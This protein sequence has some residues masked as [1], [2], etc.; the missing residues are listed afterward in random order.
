M[1]KSGSLKLHRFALAAAVLLLVCQPAFA[2]KRVALVLGNSA[3]QNVARLPNPVNDGAVIAATLK[4]ASFDVVEERHDLT[5]A[6][7]RRALRDFAD[8]AR[9]AD[10]AVVYY[11]G[12]VIE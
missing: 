1:M 12:H 6:E 11:A 10:T 4:N 9:A 2:E 3:Y 5:A 8:R 7:T